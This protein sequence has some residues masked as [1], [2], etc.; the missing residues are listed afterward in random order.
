MVDIW[1]KAD[2]GHASCF[3]EQEVA[4][5]ARGTSRDDKMTQVSSSGGIWGIE[6]CE[7]TMHKG[8]YSTY[9]VV[10]SLSRDQDAQYSSCCSQYR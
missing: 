6:L 7:M 8:E 3:A 2:F 9:G 5:V 4:F 10:Y 1:G